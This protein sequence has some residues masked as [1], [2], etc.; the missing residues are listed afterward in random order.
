M[1]CKLE[2]GDIHG[3]IRLAASDDTLAPFDEVTVEVLRSKHP[4]RVALD[5]LPPVPNSDT[6]LLL[7]QYDIMS[8]IKSFRP[9]SAGGPDGLRPQ[10]L[11]DLTN[12]ST[13]DAGQRLLCRLTEFTNLCLTGRVPAV[14]Q[15]VFCGAALCALNKKEGGIRPIAVGCTLRRMIAKAACKAVSAKM[16]PNLQPVQIGFGIPRATEAAAH[17]A[18]AYIDGLQPGEGV[19]KL[20]FKN[21]FNMVRRDVM[22]QIVHDEMPELYPFVHMCYHSASQLAFGDFLLLSDEGFQQGDPLGPLLFCISSLKL[23]R[24]MTSEFNMWYL[25]DGTLGGHVSKLLNDLETVR[26]VGSSIGLLLNEDKCEIITDDVNENSHAQHPT[27]FM[28]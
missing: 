27:Y 2:D 13:G 1:S 16:V 15:P 4:S 18:R 19:M 11:K 25:D 26:R 28:W 9:G 17:A 6:C 7:Q 14:I 21:A 5:N 24:S 22:F 20:D 8:A 23:A 10:H 3:A 12:T